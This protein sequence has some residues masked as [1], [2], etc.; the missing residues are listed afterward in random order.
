MALQVCETFAGLMGESSFAGLPGFFIR[1]RGCNLRCRY[2]DTTYA[3][4]LGIERTVES[5]VAEARASGF[6]LVLVTGGEPLLQAD[7]LPLLEALVEE[8]FT[9][10]LETNGSRPLETINSRVHRIV[11]LKCPGSGMHMHNYLKNLEYLTKAD[12]LKFVV[13]DRLDFDWALQ[14]MEPYHAWE[15]HEILVSPVFGKVSPRDLAAWILE[16]KLPLRLNLQLH[17]YI[18]P[19]EMRRVSACDYD[20]ERHGRGPAQRRFGQLRHGRGGP[21]GLPAGLLSRQLRPAHR[22]P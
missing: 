20:K 8:H 3:Y 16:S 4:D 14:T 2:C 12:E 5:L 1:L 22:P 10:L 15:R 18:W 7:C 13:S 9:V 6:G 17:K 21:A 11:D 19:P